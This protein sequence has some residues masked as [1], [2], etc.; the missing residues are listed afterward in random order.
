MRGNG[1][2]QLFGDERDQRVCQAQDRFQ[3]AQQGTAGGALLCRVAVLDLHLGDFQIPVAV[4]V[5]DE[6][7]EGLRSEVETVVGEVLADFRF[8]TLQAG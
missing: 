4:L 1:L 5:P 6:V 3:H 2:P 8:G 7:V